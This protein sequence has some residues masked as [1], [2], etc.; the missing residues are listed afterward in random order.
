MPAPTLQVRS[1]HAHAF[2][3]QSSALIIPAL[4]RSMTRLASI[5]VRG[6]IHARVRL[7]ALALLAAAPALACAKVTAIPT[8][9]PISISAKT[10]ARPLADLPPVPQPPL[11][12]RVVLDGGIVTLDEALS[13]DAEG[14]LAAEHDDIIAELA[15]W[16]AAHDEVFELA[17]EASSS[18]AGSK[19]V[20]AK[21]STALAQTVVDALRREG[22]DPDRLVAV[23][24]GKADDDQPRV[25]LRVTED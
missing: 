14:K 4:G 13:F 11:P 12:P 5:V 22:V 21:R 2:A 7:A 20:H 3:G 16:L 19:R 8:D 25:T 18:G 9:A 6:S 24:L 23:G 10:P 1:I 15:A 17:V